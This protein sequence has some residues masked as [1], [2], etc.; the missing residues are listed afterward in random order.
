MSREGAARKREPKANKEPSVAW[1]L[2]PR[3]DRR[4]SSATHAICRVLFVHNLGL[5]AT[6]SQQLFST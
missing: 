6:G 4:G 1:I 2:E 5:H 3:N